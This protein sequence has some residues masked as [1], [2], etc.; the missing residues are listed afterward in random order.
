MKVLL[1][2]LFFFY[3]VCMIRNIFKG[4]HTPPIEYFF[5]ERPEVDR[6]YKIWWVVYGL[7]F[8]FYCGVFAILMN[9][10]FR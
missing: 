1:V 6:S 7:G 10:L 9:S 4:K 5:L 2:V 8:V 3:L